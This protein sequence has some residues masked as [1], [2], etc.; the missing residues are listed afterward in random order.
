[1]ET[2]KV[3]MNGGS[4]AVRLPLSC[5]MNENEVMAHRVGDAVILF[6]K[7]S[8]WSALI[9]SLNL[10]SEDYMDEGR[11]QGAQEVRPEL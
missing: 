5:R 3:F 10:F 9:E 11:N 1:M 6:P 4:Q 2:A 7:E 8:P